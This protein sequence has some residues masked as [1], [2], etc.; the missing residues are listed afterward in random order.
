MAGVLSDPNGRDLLPRDVER[1]WRKALAGRRFDDP[2]P[3]EDHAF[4][5]TFA[6]TDTGDSPDRC[7]G[8]SIEPAGEA[9][10]SEGGQRKTRTRKRKTKTGQPHARYGDFGTPER[11]RRGPLIIEQLS[12]T[13]RNRGNR[14]RVR[15]IEVDDPLFVYRRNRVISVLQRD[16]GLI[17]REFWNRTGRSPRV[18]APYQEA[19]SRGSAEGVHIASAEHHRRFVEAIRAVGPIGSDTLVTVVCL[20]E[21]I[22][23]G[24]YEILRRGLDILANRFGLADR[25][26]DETGSP[27]S[28]EGVR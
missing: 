12:E 11:A 10:M 6:L 1:A 7:D 14:V 20:Q 22:P 15:A 27:R 28:D 24:H 9:S 17:L 3:S 21:F 19:V 5:R 4:L 26:L 8:N 25:P 13:A 18:V 23:R 16:A 2:G